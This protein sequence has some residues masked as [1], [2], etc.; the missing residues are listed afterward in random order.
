MSATTDPCRLEGPRHFVSAHQL[1]ARDDVIARRATSAQLATRGSVNRWSTQ[2]VAARFTRSAEDP[3]ELAGC[4]EP[5]LVATPD[6]GASLRMIAVPGTRKGTIAVPGAVREQSATLTA[7]AVRSAR[8]SPMFASAG[9]EV[10]P[11]AG[12]AR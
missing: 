2:S 10:G 9:T 11:A 3:V 5:V 1:M 4:M 12:D 8:T 6:F 7:R